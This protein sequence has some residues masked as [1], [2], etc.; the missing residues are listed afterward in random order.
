M[1]FVKSFK[2]V[3]VHGRNEK[4]NIILFFWRYQAN[5]FN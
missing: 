2:H 5:H 3:L 1:L 4:V